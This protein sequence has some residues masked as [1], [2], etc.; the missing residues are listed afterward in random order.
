[1]FE[2]GKIKF[3]DIKTFL[4]TNPDGVESSSV[5]GWSAPFKMPNELDA[6][7]QAIGS[8]RGG[9]SYTRSSYSFS[10]FRGIT[11]ADLP[12]ITSDLIINQT[13]TSF[14]FNFSYQI[15]A[16]NMSGD[17]NHPFLYTINNNASVG[18]LTV[19]N[20]GLISGVIDVSS[21]TIVNNSLTLSFNAIAANYAG[22]SVQPIT[23]NLTV[24]LPNEKPEIEIIGLNPKYL[25]TGDTYNDEGATAFD[26][27]DG[28]L[29][30]SI[31]T[32]N[33]V[34]T[35]V[36]GTYQVKYNVQD[37]QGLAA[38]EKIRTVIVN[39]PA[40]DPPVITRT[41]PASVTIVQNTTYTDQGATASDAQ[42][43]N[44]TSRIV[45]VNPVNTSVPATYRITYNVT[46]LGGLS[47]D[48]VT[49]IVVVE[50]E[51]NTPPTITL[52]G[53]AAV[54]VNAGST[55]TD[56]GATAT[57]AQDGNLTSQIVVTTSEGG[58]SAN[59]STTNPRALTITYTVTDSG[60]MS[61][62]T[63]RQVTIVNTPPVIT[64]IGDPVVNIGPPP[65]PTSTLPE[66]F[67]TAQQD[68]DPTANLDGY[69][70]D[71][72]HYVIR[73]AAV[74]RSGQFT[75]R[76]QVYEFYCYGS[77][78]SFVTNAPN[79]TPFYTLQA[80]TLSLFNTSICVG[81]ASWQYSAQAG[82]QEMAAFGLVYDGTRNSILLHTLDTPYIA[83]NVNVLASSQN[84]RQYI[85]PQNCSTS[86]SLDRY[87]TNS[88][89]SGGRGVI[90][91]NNGGLTSHI[92][93]LQVTAGT[94]LEQI[95]IYPIKKV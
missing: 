46:D 74:Q 42:D 40:N 68:C 89:A 95:S 2:E 54:S 14:I 28:S 16:S 53:S 38:D 22:A 77:A 41:G 85:H 61:A 51:P 13:I 47:A 15:V 32:T 24:S 29:T 31:V 87:D 49:R 18:S 64:L 92:E 73:Y 84:Y 48:Q 11:K 19:S 44:I 12:V 71:E 79:F 33:P 63:S 81:W 58:T 67:I 93:A 75:A 37:S 56:Q 80:K 70:Y 20:T 45:T 62:S 10:E 36:A 78:S 6:F 30:S 76:G 5:A 91:E 82:G 3:S 34:N 57:D 1:M 21:K 90:I 94:D 8:L 66:D 26:P 39:L 35:A 72:N 88:A 4:E 17:K 27:E 86:D 43:G 60:G 7:G 83:S 65:T 55:Y 9:S 50:P 23:L 69:L 52:T 59:I 25:I